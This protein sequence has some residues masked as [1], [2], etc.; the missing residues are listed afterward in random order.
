MTS[1]EPPTDQD[2][3]KPDTLC[4]RDGVVLTARPP[5]I[6]SI[7]AQEFVPGP[8]RLRVAPILR[9][10]GYRNIDRVARPIREAAEEMVTVAEQLV[11]P[12]I[13]FARRLIERVDGEML[14]LQEGPT[15]HGRC[16]DTH[17]SRAREAVCFL[18]TIGPALDERVSG[19]ADAGDLLE[20]LLLDTAGW[21]AI[22]G[23]LRAFRVDLASR[24]HPDRLRLSP[25]L[26]PGFLDW[27]LTEQV[28]FFSVFNG[29]SV[30]VTVSEYC[31]M[32][33][34]KSISGLFGLIRVD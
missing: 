8:I 12:R 6:R 4:R 34:K 20:A 22:E 5:S 24:V 21:L 30:P 16:F 26:G 25:R 33:P 23:A 13:V 28:Q 3:G 10:Q 2:W 19:L 14:V 7:R 11:D 9:F 18:A 17:L 31:V 15:F 29:M 1:Q 32:T 27:S